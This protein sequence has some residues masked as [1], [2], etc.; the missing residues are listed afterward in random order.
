L[1]KPLGDTPLQTVDT[2]KKE[3][4]SYAQVPLTYS[5]RLDPLASGKLLVLAGDE[6]K[7]RKTYDDLDKEYEFEVLLKFQSDTGDLLGLAEEGPLTRRYS[8]KSMKKL[9]RS[10]RG[11]HELPYPAY[12]SKTVGGKALHRHAREGTLGS[13][14]MPIAKMRVYSMQFESLKTL[15]GAELLEKILAKLVLVKSDGFRNDEI[16]ARWSELL[17]ASTQQYTV[18][19]FRA[20]T[21]SGTYIR[22]LAPLMASRLGTVGL[23]YSIHRSTIGK[24]VPMLLG[25]GFWLKTFS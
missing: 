6:C 21:G 9:A 3:H 8:A 5:G 13:V 17:R 18:A 12:S 2:F 10:M 16:A 25:R 20:R 19:R 15:T 23:A 7:H 14:E 4:E 22:A 11:V 24:Y 1:E